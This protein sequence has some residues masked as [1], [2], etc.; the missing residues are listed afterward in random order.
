MIDAQGAAS[1]RCRTA[2]HDKSQNHQLQNT[3][4][5]FSPVHRHYA[6]DRKKL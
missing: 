1:S 6:A 5:V 4:C 2:C 3:H